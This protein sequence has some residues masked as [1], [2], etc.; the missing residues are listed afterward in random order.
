MISMQL[1][2][3]DYRNENTNSLNLHWYT[4]NLISV[5]CRSLYLTAW[6]NSNDLV[7]NLWTFDKMNQ[8]DYT[9]V[10]PIHGI[11]KLIAIIHILQMHP[12][13]LFLG[14]YLCCLLEFEIEQI[15]SSF[16]IR[17]F[18]RKQRPWTNCLGLSYLRVTYL[19]WQ[20]ISHFINTTYWSTFFSK[21][22]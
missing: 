15:Q 8:T 18:C 2:N 6:G 1:S 19:Y 7:V 16:Q 3:K 22:S 12:P 9:A 4:L 11:Y 13:A 10:I 17:M 14:W 5:K 20:Y 21:I